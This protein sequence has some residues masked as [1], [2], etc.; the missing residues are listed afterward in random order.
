VQTLPRRPV[1]VTRDRLEPGAGALE[2]LAGILDA[3]AAKLRDLGGRERVF[4][5]L[6]DLLDVPGRVAAP[7]DVRVGF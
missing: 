2:L 7:P 3:D 6:E 5:P 4:R 1:S